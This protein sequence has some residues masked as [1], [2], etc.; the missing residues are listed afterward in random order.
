MR[1]PGALQSGKS[2]LRANL[3]TFRDGKVVQMVAYETPEGA[4]AAT[5]P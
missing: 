2:E 3:A 4:L 1:P 5:Q